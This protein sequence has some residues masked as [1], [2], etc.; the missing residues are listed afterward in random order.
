MGSDRRCRSSKNLLNNVRALPQVGSDKL[1]GECEKDSDIWSVQRR[2]NRQREALPCSTGAKVV[3]AYDLGKSEAR[4]TR[5]RCLV[6][7]E[8]GKVNNQTE[9]FA[10]QEP[11]REFQSERCSYPQKEEEALT[12]DGVYGLE[13]SE[14]ATSDNEHWN[15]KRTLEH[16]ATKH[17]GQDTM[18]GLK[19]E[20]WNRRLGEVTSAINVDCRHTR[21]HVKQDQE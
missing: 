21:S 14:P 11:Q 12:T 7:T 18:R 3:K 4:K 17:L 8:T 19:Q 9:N 5:A 13:S 1:T 20:T 2:T 10:T 6:R 16:A 15:H